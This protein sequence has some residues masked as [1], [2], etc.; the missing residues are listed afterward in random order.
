MYLLP[1][2]NKTRKVK[3]LPLPLQRTIPLSKISHGKKNDCKSLQVYLK[4]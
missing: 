4:K 1:D 3:A 2:P